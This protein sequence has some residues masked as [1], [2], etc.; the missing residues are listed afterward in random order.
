MPGTYGFSVLTPFAVLCVCLALAVFSGVLRFQSAAGVLT[1]I[2]DTMFLASAA[3]AIVSLLWLLS[4][5]AKAWAAHE[6]NRA[7]EDDTHR[8]ENDTDQRP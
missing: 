6:T 5:A 2:L 8:A 4:R 3:C 1:P 7:A